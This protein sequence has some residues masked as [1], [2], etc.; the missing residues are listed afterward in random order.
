MYQYVEL[1]VQNLWQL[2]AV[3]I[4][5]WVWRHPEILQRVE[6]LKVGEIEVKLQELESEIETLESEIEQERQVFRDI[7]Q[8]FDP[9]APSEELDRTRELLKAHARTLSDI[10]TIAP[11]LREDASPE[12]L[13][14]AAVAFRERRPTQLVGTLLDCMERLS[15]RSDLG[16]VR[17]QTVWTLVSALHRTLISAIRDRAE[18]II[19]KDELMRADEILQRLETNPR[20][21]ADRPDNPQKGVRGPIKHARSWIKKG[22]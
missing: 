10:D 6:S 20:I 11:Y 8:G 18:P 17:L 14:A 9:S 22:L 16:D 1:I 4:V 7:I 19:P 3:G 21:Q 2:I 13:Y 5:A 15:N 12:E